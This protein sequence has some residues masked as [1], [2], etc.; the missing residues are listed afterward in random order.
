MKITDEMI[1]AAALSDAEFDGRNFVCMGRVDRDRYMLRAKASLT[2]ALSASPAGVKVKE[3]EWGERVHGTW[4][5]FAAVAYSAFQDMGNGKYFVR[6]AFPAEDFLGPFDTLEAAKSAAQADYS[7]RIMSAI[8]PAGVKTVKQQDIEDLHKL[9][10]M[11]G[12]TFKPHE[13]AGVGVETPPPSTH[14]AGCQDI[15]TAPAN[16]DVL[17]WWPTVKLDDDG[18]PTEEVVGG[19]WLI[20]EK[21]GGYWIEPE[22]MN[23]IGDHMGD[24]HT[25]ADKPSHWMP[26]P[27]ALFTATTEGST[28]V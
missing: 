25:Y 12:A 15:S 8:E 20:S 19:C 6:L 3:L 22:C 28:D 4:H 27:A 10:E 18:D 23:A 5:A 17:V 26:L 2:A 11:V 7:T 1:E 21:Q 24:D 9:A 13:P 14:V 16:T